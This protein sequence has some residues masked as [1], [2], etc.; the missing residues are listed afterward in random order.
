MLNS[1]GQIG[2]AE[3]GALLNW[4]VLMGTISWLLDLQTIDEVVVLLK[5]CQGLHVPH[6]PLWFSDFPPNQ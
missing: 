5:T 6:F 3:V 2:R 1:I 4:R